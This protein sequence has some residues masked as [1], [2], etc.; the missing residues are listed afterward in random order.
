M[1]DVKISELTANTTPAAAD[2][3]AVTNAAGSATNKVTLQNIAQMFSDDTGVTG[4]DRI[5]NV[6]SLTSSEYS[7]ITPD[8]S[9]LYILTD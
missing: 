9:T 3:A 1:A 5:T 8:A 2:V 7:S 6:I 4:A